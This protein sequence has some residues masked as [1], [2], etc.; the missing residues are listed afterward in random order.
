MPGEKKKFF[1]EWEWAQKG[2]QKKY[3]KSHMEWEQD[4]DWNGVV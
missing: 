2:L 3:L 1:T 4:S